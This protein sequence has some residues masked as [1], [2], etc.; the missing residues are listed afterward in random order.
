M[1]DFLKDIWGERNQENSDA[2][3]AETVEVTSD[4]DDDIESLT[5]VEQRIARLE[6][7]METVV[8]IL[9]EIRTQQVEQNKE[10]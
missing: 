10:I 7:Q 9:Q 4:E 8:E 1:P 5:S 2:N 6:G 3:T